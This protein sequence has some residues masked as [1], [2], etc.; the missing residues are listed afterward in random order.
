MTTKTISSAMRNITFALLIAMLLLLGVATV[1]EKVKGTQFV[2]HNIYES[3]YFILLWCL[4]GVSATIYLIRQHIYRRFAVMLLHLSFLL[5]LSGAAVT[6]FTSQR[7]VIKLTEGEKVNEYITDSGEICR[8]PIDVELKNFIVEHYPGTRSPMNF[9]AE[10]A[11][12]DK[13]AQVSM[14]K[15]AEID[16]FQFCLK[17]YNPD[18]KG[19]TMSV[20]SDRIGVG[21][22]FAGY[23]LLFGS[24]M[25]LLINPKSRFNLLRK[26]LAT[27]SIILIIGCFAT[28]AHNI[29]TEKASDGFRKVLIEN[30]DRIMPFETF[31]DNVLM[32]V[33][34][35]KSYKS[36]NSVQ[37]IVDMYLNSESW[38]EEPIFRLKDNE[39]RLLL[40]ITGKYASYNDFITDQNVY[41][42]HE[43]MEA[44]SRGTY[45]GDAR[46][47]EEANERFQMIRMVMEGRLFKIFPLKDTSSGLLRWYCPAEKLPMDIDSDKFAFFKYSFNYMTEMLIT[48]N[49]DNFVST[50]NKI[51]EYQRKEGGNLLPS[52]NQVKAE[53]IYNSLDFPMSMIC[54]T[55]GLIGWIA[56]LYFQIKDKSR[57][58]NLYWLQPTMKI[59]IWIVTVYLSVIFALKWYVGNH[60]PL[61]N[62]AETMQFMALMIGIVYLSVG[63]RISLSLPITFMLIGFMLLVAMIGNSNPPVTQLMP[64]LNSPLLSIHVVVIMIS[65]ALIGFITLNSITALILRTFHHNETKTF[66]RLQLSNEVMLYPAVFLLTAGI[67]IGAMWANISWGRYWGWDPKEVWALITLLIYGLML[68]PKSLSILHR[69]D[70]FHRYLVIASL[71]VAITYFGVNYFLG[72]VHSYA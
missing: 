38:G 58:N 40:G 68:H 72:G 50:A 16:G 47:V 7:G 41:K 61:G 25:W 23:W 51:A 30:N 1:V 11:S 27:L 22:S 9:H 33:H 29:V 66:E 54:L 10:I 31:A 64:V 13:T 15:T 14:N 19:V 24:M 20:A 36:M 6:F 32:K 42:L 65:Y 71:S 5:I 57:N 17:G 28:E 12:G 35:K 43:P 59:L 62:G 3:P 37:V 4:L 2:S 70:V 56:T 55:I 49:D 53:L 63:K 44:V 8:L 60:I 46:T 67:F 45:K 69:P 26:K 18:L 48:G 52:E 34:G 39:V 21:L